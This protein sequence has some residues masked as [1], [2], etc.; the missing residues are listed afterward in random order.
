MLYLLQSQACAIF[1]YT[2]VVVLWGLNTDVCGLVKCQL[3]RELLTLEY[4]KLFAHLNPPMM[5]IVMARRR[6]PPN[7]HALSKSGATL[8]PNTL[9][10]KCYK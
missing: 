8:G 2:K 5:H 1:F 4:G 10:G 9:S 6:S 3:L 7:I